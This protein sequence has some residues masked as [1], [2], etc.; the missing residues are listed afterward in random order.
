M[1]GWRALALRLLLA[2][3][4]GVSPRRREW[5]A[6]ALAELDAVAPGREAALWTLGIA[7]MVLRDRLA[8]ALLPWRVG[9]GRRP[10]ARF[11]AL[12]GLAL[13]AG[14][15]WRAWAGGVPGVAPGFAAGVATMLGL[16][17]NAG[18]VLRAQ[19]LGG[20]HHAVGIRL[21]PLNLAVAALAVAVGVAL[22]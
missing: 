3:A 10:P 19:P 2:S 4:A 18:A 15:A 8:Q 22:L 14:P 12:L 13:L 20:L 6:A 5:V 9:P 11:V 21:L 1:S 7:R 17:I 16:W